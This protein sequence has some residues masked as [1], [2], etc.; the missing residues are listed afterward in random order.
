M[1]LLVIVWSSMSCQ[2]G[3][4]PSSSCQSILTVIGQLWPI[5]ISDWSP[6]TTGP[7]S[8]HRYIGHTASSHT[9]HIFVF[10]QYLVLLLKYQS[11]K[12]L[13]SRGIH[14]EN[15]LS[16]TNNCSQWRFCSQILV[17]NCSLLMIIK[18]RSR[19]GNWKILCDAKVF[20]T[21]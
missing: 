6:L 15:E 9:Y 7:T 20:R 21:E 3:M 4:D 13:I 14:S 16:V 19:R 17:V 8:G 11:S 18:M 5:L 10:L 1:C 2:P 12:F